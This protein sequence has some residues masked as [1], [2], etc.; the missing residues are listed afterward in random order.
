MLAPACVGQIDTPLGPMLA[1]LDNRERLLRLEFTGDPAFHKFK[2]AKEADW[3]DAMCAPVAGQLAEYF[4]GTRREFELPLTP[5]GSDFQ[6]R[7]WNELTLIPYGET[8]TY[9]EIARRLDLSPDAARAV[10]S[11]NG[12]N[13]IAII[14][15]C[16][17]VIG[18]NG[19]LTGYA[20]GLEH[21]RRLL[22]LEGAL[23]PQLFADFEPPSAA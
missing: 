15:P 4:A 14:V 9:G 17:R 7:V 11:A 5:Q 8:T 18:A 6:R 20:Y 2:I 16:H 3:D 19:A 1:V 23:T 12:A 10:G 22:E 21:K 13:P